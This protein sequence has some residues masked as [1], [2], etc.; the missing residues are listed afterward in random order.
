MHSKK[1]IGLILLSFATTTYAAEGWFV[2]DNSAETLDVSTILHDP[3]SGYRL[4]TPQAFHDD[5]YPWQTADKPLTDAQKHQAVVWELSEKEETRYLQ[6]IE[7]RAAIYYQD[8]N[9]T[10]VEILGFNARDDKERQHYADLEAKQMVERS[11]R[12]KAYGAAVQASMNTLFKASG[13]PAVRSFDHQKYS[14]LNQQALHI[15][16]GDTLVLFTKTTDQVKPVT[17]ELIALIAKTQKT[18]LNIFLI[19]PNL[20]IDAANKWARGQSIPVSLVEDKKITLN[21]SEGQFHKVVPNGQTPTLIL[22]HQGVSEL[23]NIGKF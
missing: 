5:I 21:L 19:D 12:E 14:P 9:M 17:S 8:K 13:Y 23:V 7:N 3:N 10:P 1:I 20:T 16:A 11:S 4:R 18:Q 22:I 2:N 6:L 15:E